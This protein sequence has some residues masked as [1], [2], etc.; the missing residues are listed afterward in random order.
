[1]ESS[2]IFLRNGVL[3]LNGKEN[4]EATEICF[5]IRIPKKK[6]KELLLK[7]PSKIYEVILL[8]KRR[9]K[10]SGLLIFLN[11]ITEQWGLCLQYISRNLRFTASAIWTGK[12]QQN[13]MKNLT[14]EWFKIP[15]PTILLCQKG[16]Y[17]R[18]SPTKNLLFESNPIP[19]KLIAYLSPSP[20]PS[21]YICILPMVLIQHLLS[22]NQAY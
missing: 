21:H 5:E 17:F 13:F 2:V 7:V 9:K 12:I 4:N 18:T 1:M 6:N 14:S 16:H 15:L 11:I 20:S 22:T 10:K 8:W 19:P 3:V